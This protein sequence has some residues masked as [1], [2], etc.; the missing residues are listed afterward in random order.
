MADTITEFI[1]VAG[2][3]YSEVSGAGITILENSASET[4]VIK[5]V[6]ISNSRARTLSFSV[7]PTEIFSNSGNDRVSGTE[8]VGAGTKVKMTTSTTAIFN[9]YLA[10]SWS[11]TGVSSYVTTIETFFNDS[12]P[13][14]STRS[15][16]SNVVNGQVCTVQ[17]N[18]NCFDAAGNWYYATV[19]DTPTTGSGPGISALGKNRLY[20]RAGGV[21]GPETAV[22]SGFP[23]TAAVPTYQNYHWDGA[24]YIHAI[25]WDYNA[26][27]NMA[28][29]PMM[30]TYDTVNGVVT[31]FA[32]TAIP[33]IG[34]TTAGS[35]ATMSISSF[36]DYIFVHTV[37]AL[38]AF[39]FILKTYIG[40]FTLSQPNPNSDYRSSMVAGKDSSGNYIV[41]LCAPSSGGTDVK[42]YNLGRDISTG[43]P[44]T[45]IVTTVSNLSFAGYNYTSGGSD[46]TF[47]GRW[48]KSPIS[49]N[50]V[51]LFALN[52]IQVVNLD[53]LTAGSIHP[54][55]SASF[56]SITGNVSLL[57][58]DTTIA[59][60]DYGT[61]GVRAT[62]IK[63]T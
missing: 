34:T 18:F 6:Y 56:S 61:I 46:K 51:F 49:P 37:S 7:G 35:P 33:S 31:T 22:F 36:G 63:T 60:I 3:K 1:N 5:D 17:P 38:Y 59:D 57:P 42:I 27:A 15:K 52:S 8:L 43:L 19:V 41:L 40:L 16:I 30:M 12:A 29:N 13:A 48:V 9:Q 58:V 55:S 32:L 39:N 45:P 24:R 26:A 53:T 25:Y 11:G 14:L 44:N 54:R 20:K 50:L 2:K 28:S 23:S 10:I 47:T 62:G 4:A 21:N